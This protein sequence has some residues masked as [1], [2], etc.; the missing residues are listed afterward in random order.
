MNCGR[1]HSAAQTVTLFWGL[2]GLLVEGQ[3]GLEVVLSGL[4]TIIDILLGYLLWG[5]RTVIGIHN[6]S[7]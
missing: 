4:N 3:V 6:M 5:V 7:I 2:N 1:V